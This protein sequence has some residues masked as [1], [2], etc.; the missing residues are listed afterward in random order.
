[1]MLLRVGR[2]STGTLQGV[3]FVRYSILN[4]M[5]QGKS[6]QDNV[7][8]IAYN[9]L[10]DTQVCRCALNHPSRHMLGEKPYYNKSNNNSRRAIR[11]Q[12][13]DVEDHASLLKKWSRRALTSSKVNV[14]SSTEVTAKS[15]ER[16]GYALVSLSC[17]T[18][19]KGAVNLAS[20]RL[21]APN[22]TA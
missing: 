21:A 16:P 13:R 14:R 20:Y 11:W 1:M 4:Q 9:S 8:T 3:R 15:P 10:L 19:T 2:R 17:H 18:A 12:S 22:F 7:L 5:A 6:R